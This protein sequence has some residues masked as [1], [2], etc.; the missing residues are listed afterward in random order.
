MS[1][2]SNAR[3]EILNVVN[4]IEVYTA[5]RPNNEMV[6]LTVKEL[7]SHLNKIKKSVNDNLVDNQS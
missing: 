7:Q 3:K 1:S 6:H 5:G 4:D 2:V